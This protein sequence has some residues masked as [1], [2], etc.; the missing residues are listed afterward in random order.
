MEKGCIFPAAIM[1]PICGN[2]GAVGSVVDTKWARVGSYQGCSCGTGVAP[3]GDVIDQAA[4]IGATG[5]PGSNGEV[6][7]CKIYEA[8]LI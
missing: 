7:E 2:S 5:D 1:S 4:N 3:A 6:R 8:H